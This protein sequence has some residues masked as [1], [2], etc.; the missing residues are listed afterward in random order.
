MGDF[1]FWLSKLV[2]REPR[3]DELI[4]DPSTA[5]G[6]MTPFSGQKARH[7]KADGPGCKH[8]LQGVLIQVQATISHRE[9]FGFNTFHIFAEV[10]LFPVGFKNR[11]DMFPR[12][13]ANGPLSWWFG[14]IWI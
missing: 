11:L 4:L 6:K 2:P 5:L 9:A 12:E 3:A 7:K 13:G 10:A 8:L 1:S 14:L